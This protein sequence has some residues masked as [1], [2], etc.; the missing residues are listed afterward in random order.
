MSTGYDYSRDTLLELFLRMQFP[1]RTPKESALIRDFL[2]A[3][4]HEYEPYSFT[5]RVGQ[6]VTPNP[7]HLPGVQRQT[8]LNSQMRI[9]MLAWQGAQPFIFEVKERATHAAI[10]QLLTYRHL[11]MEEHPDDPAP[12][13]AVIA[14]TIDPDMERVFANSDV[15][16]Y[17][18][19]PAAGDGGAAPGGVSTL[20]GASA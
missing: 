1:E 18:Y 10:G 3:H 17:L 15:T 13:L 7:D 14:R 12:Q 20:D 8:V 4:I 6:G 5:V 9:D 19:P 2:Q 11:W 16:V